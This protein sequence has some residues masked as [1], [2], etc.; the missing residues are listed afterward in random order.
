ML[1]IPDIFLGWTVDAGSEPTYLGI[2][3][4][5]YCITNQEPNAKTTQR[6]KTTKNE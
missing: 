6:I 1:E 2:K 3:D 4:T 5:N